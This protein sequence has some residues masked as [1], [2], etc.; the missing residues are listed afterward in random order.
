MNYYLT[1][2]VLYTYKYGGRRRKAK[3]NGDRL[4]HSRKEA[5][6]PREHISCDHVSHRSR[7]ANAR[8]KQHYISHGYPVIGGAYT[9]PYQYV[10]G[11]SYYEGIYEIKNIATYPQY[12]RK[13]YGRRLIHFLCENYRHKCHTMLVGTG[14][15]PLTVPF[16]ESCGFTYSHRIPH[17]F[18]DHYDHPIIEAGKLLTDMVY[19]KKEL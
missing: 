15:S 18:T 10:Y 8:D 6:Y 5:Q 1:H 12:Q 17:F 13:G 7:K 14:E 19:F 3:A 16:Y 11:K 2:K 9:Y 4:Y